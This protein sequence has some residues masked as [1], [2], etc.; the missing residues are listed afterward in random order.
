MPKNVQSDY[1]PETLEAIATS[2]ESYASDLRALA[3]SMRENKLSS[4]AIRNSVG[5]DQAP[6]KITKFLQAAN[7]QLHVERVLAATKAKG[8]GRGPKKKK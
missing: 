2:F 6:G 1:T 7:E 5:F 8:D 4:M 3:V